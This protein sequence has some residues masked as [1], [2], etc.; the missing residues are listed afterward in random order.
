MRSFIV[1]VFGFLTCFTLLASIVKSSALTAGHAHVIDDQQTNSHSRV[2]AQFLYTRRR[3]CVHHVSQMDFTRLPHVTEHRPRAAADGFDTDPCGL[4]GPRQSQHMISLSNY[5]SNRPEL[6]WQ[7]RHFTVKAE[8]WARQMQSKSSLSRLSH[9]GSGHRFDSEINSS[10]QSEGAETLLGSAPRMHATA[11]GQLQSLT[12]SSA[13]GV[14]YRTSGLLRPV[15]NQGICG[16][17]WAHAATHAADDYRALQAQTQPVEWSSIQDVAECTQD[18]YP[19]SQGCN[20]GIPAQAVSYLYDIGSVAAS[21][22]AY[23]GTEGNLGQYMRCRSKCDNGSIP[24]YMPLN[25]ETAY[26]LVSPFL[27]TNGSVAA[28][29]NALQNGPFPVAFTCYPDFFSYSGGIYKPLAGQTSGQG[30]AVE[31][32]GFGTNNQGVDYFIAKNSWGSGWGLGGYFYIQAGT[33]DLH[34]YSRSSNSNDGAGSGFGGTSAAAPTNSL[35]DASPDDELVVE[36]IQ[37]LL[38]GVQVFCPVSTQNAAT[39]NSS[40]SSNS[41]VPNLL[42]AEIQVLTAHTQLAAGLTFSLALLV[43]V[44]DEWCP[45]QFQLQGTVIMNLQAE[46]SI[47]SVYFPPMQTNNVINIVTNSTGYSGSYVAGVTVG[48]LIALLVLEVLIYYF[49]RKGV[50]ARF[51]GDRSKADR[52]VALTVG[53]HE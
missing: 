19:N 1:V 27:F 6:G 18:H 23:T 40:K 44:L 26:N 25:F 24:I 21:C 14:D 12:Q 53:A 28:M 3:S 42:S 43:T 47:A 32:V 52:E 35:V 37:T 33:A 41:T 46:M 48:C 51:I 15:S 13:S 9:T 4:R 10:G 2:G 30:H 39:L 17:C 8:H 16:S 49:I 34:P 11:V 5:V 36:A 45:Q 29:Q 22:K 20:G 50:C 38:D 7:A 31:L